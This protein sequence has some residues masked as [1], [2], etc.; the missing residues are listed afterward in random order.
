MR[1]AP[2]GRPTFRKMQGAALADDDPGAI[3]PI[4]VTVAR[5]APAE[6]HAGLALPVVAVDAQLHAGAVGRTSTH[7]PAVTFVVAHHGRRSRTRGHRQHSDAEQ[8]LAH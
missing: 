6:L 5:L 2:K 7:A 3:A 8:R 4:A 1:T